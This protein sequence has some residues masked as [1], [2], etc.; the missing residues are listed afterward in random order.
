MIKLFSGGSSRKEDDYDY[1]DDDDYPRNQRIKEG[2]KEF[3][4]IEMKFVKAR[5][6][7]KAQAKHKSDDNDVEYD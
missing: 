5:Q 4:D 7:G 2:D 3:E 1:D 6:G